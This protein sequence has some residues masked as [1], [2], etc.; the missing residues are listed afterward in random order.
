MG[1][2]EARQLLQLYQNQSPRIKLEFIDPDRH[3]ELAE[4]SG[5]STYGT[6]VFDYQGQRTRIV[7]P[8]EDRVSGA[9]IKVSRKESWAI[10]F[11]TGHGEADPEQQDKGGMSLIKQYLESQNYQVKPLQ[12]SAQ[13]IPED[14]RVIVAAGPRMPYQ[15]VEIEA[16]DHYL[17]KGGDA[18]FMLDPMVPTNLEAL[19]QGYGAAPLVGI[20]IDPVNYLTGMDAV[21][22]TVVANTF[23]P[24]HEITREL[25]GKL[26]AFPRTQALRITAGPE[27]AGKW[28]PLV[29]SSASSF[30]E[31][32]LEEFRQ[33]RLYQGPENPKG[34]LLLACA[35]S[36]ELMVKPWEQDKKKPGQIRIALLGNTFFMRNMALEIYSNYIM[37]IN[38]FNWAAGEQELETIIPKARMPSRVFI[39]ARQ[40]QLIFYSSVLIIPEMLCVLG[41]AVWW[42]RKK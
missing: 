28:I 1:Y 30:L 36:E 8:R 9:L 13:G 39:T 38:L 23:D 26:V 31:T 22:L 29:Y 19:L 10:Y 33:G 21:G 25:K 40:T 15:Q 11:I 6:V 2:D 41:L 24:N 17:G 5:I 34:P 16:I 27:Q 32:N 18:I 4:A 14:A 12:I 37:A 35:Y 7:D 42:W 3:P 20:V